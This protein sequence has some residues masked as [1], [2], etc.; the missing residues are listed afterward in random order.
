M[1]L[2]VDVLFGN[3]RCPHFLRPCACTP[4]HGMYTWLGGAT[5]RYAGTHTR[6]HTYTL[7]H[8]PSRPATPARACLRRCSTRTMERRSP[9]AISSLGHVSGLSHAMMEEALHGGARVQ[10][11]QQAPGDLRTDASFIR[12]RAV[13]EQVLGD[14]GRQTCCSPD[15]TKEVNAF[16]IRD[17]KHLMRLDRESTI[18][19][20]RR[21]LD[22]AVVDSGLPLTNL[23]SIL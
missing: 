21:V 20:H 6:A 7:T 2:F 10:G 13:V 9:P 12:H 5:Y 8:T 16:L 22:S 1:C 19:L 3:T 15:T 18:T 17:L 23:C 14:R 4:H 11:P